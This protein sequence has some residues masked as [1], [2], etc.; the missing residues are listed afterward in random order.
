MLVCSRVCVEGWEGALT[1]C[2]S[3]IGH[4]ILL[5]LPVPR[6]CNARIFVRVSVVMFSVI[7]WCLLTIM[8]CL[9]R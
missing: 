5:L 7:T 9:L 2:L 8:M 1:S 3:S 4:E 6:S